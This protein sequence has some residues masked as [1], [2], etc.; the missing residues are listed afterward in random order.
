MHDF[1]VGLEKR[2]AGKGIG[3]RHFV[4]DKSSLYNH[5]ENVSK[6]HTGTIIVCTEAINKS[7]RT[8]RFQYRIQSRAY[9]PLVEGV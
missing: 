6:T 7:I 5:L 8:K 3:V 1:H 2:G 9:S 4:Y